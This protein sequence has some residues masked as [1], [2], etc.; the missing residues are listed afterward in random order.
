MCDKNVDEIDF[1]SFS[2][3]Q[4]LCVNFTNILQAAF[5]PIYACQKITKPSC[6]RE[7]A[8]SYKKNARVKC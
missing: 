8:F 2:F 4:D 7:K 6:I 1:R 5:A 3:F